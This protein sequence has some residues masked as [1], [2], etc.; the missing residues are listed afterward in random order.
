MSHTSGTFVLRILR[1]FSS[2]SIAALCPTHRKSE[3]LSK[4]AEVRTLT[5]STVFHSTII[6]SA[7]STSDT[8]IA[9]FPNFAPH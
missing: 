4:T 3:M 9:G 1:C 6:R 7:H 2:L 8:K 5:V